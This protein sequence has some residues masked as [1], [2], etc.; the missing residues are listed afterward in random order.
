M[1]VPRARQ[2]GPGTGAGGRAD[3]ADHAEP[4]AGQG[5][6]HAFAV[7][8][9]VPIGGLT[10][11]GAR[12]L[13][14]RMIDHDDALMRI[15]LALAQDAADA[16]EAPIGAVLVDPATGAVVA[17]APIAFEYHERHRSPTMRNATP[18]NSAT[19]TR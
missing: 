5:L 4:G 19:S 6:G 16:G 11:T 9:A 2:G 10:G 13:L 17:S 15:A 7:L 8:G 14:K 1:A 3:S 12:A 18:A